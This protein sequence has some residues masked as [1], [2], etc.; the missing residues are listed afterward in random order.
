M[1][2]ATDSWTSSFSPLLDLVWPRQCPLCERIGR[3][4]P[5]ADCLDGFEP[6]GTD[7]SGPDGALDYRIALYRYSGRAGQAV[8]K[9]KYARRTSLVP[10][11]SLLIAQAIQERGLEANLVVPVPIHWSRRCARGFN[12]AE[13]LAEGVPQRANALARVRRTRPQAGLSREERLKNLDGAFRTT[14]DVTGLRILLVD[15]VLTSGQTARECAKALKAAGAVEVG[16][17]ALCGE[18]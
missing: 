6:L 1:P 4:S 12:Q 18:I 16:V 15:D 9:L 17:L 2:K 3:A 10:S 7:E 11:L 13:A 8:R 14:Q 5:C